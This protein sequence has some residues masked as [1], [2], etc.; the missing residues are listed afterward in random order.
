MTFTLPE[1]ELRLSELDRMMENLRNTI[2][3][4][5]FELEC[6]KLQ[7]LVLIDKIAELKAK[8]ELPS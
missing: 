5:T 4:E 6:L 8:Q 2:C 3:T 7:K 1:L